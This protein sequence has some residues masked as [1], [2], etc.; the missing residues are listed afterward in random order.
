MPEF[1]PKIYK[2]D[3]IKNLMRESIVAHTVSHAYIIE[4]PD[5]SGK[6]TFAL[7]IAA[8]LSCKNSGNA[9]AVPCGECEQCEKILHGMSTDVMIIDSGDKSTIGIDS[10]RRMKEDM[11]L[12][13]TEN[14][15]KVYIID[16]AQL[17]TVQAQNAL[18]KV[19]EEPPKNTVVML[20][21]DDAKNILIT[22]KS[23][24]RL[25]RM[26]LFTSEEIE[27]YILS[28]SSAARDMKKNSS[29]RFGTLVEG[30]NGKIGRALDLLNEEKLSE[31]TEQRKLTDKI[32][33]AI[34]SS[35]GFFPIYD[36]ITA[37]P[38][39]RN[40]LIDVFSSVLCAMRDIFVIKKYASSELCYYYNRDDAIKTA[41]RISLG[42]LSSVITLTENAVTETGKNANISLLLTKFATDIHKLS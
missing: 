35:H 36:A 19:L 6:M 5:G 37:L 17:L 8:A 18:L 42:K 30:A 20:L 29:D 15:Y 25:M 40:E 4:G 10:V 41:R 21:C 26:Q 2:N 1:F 32:I 3:M 9:D 39:K 13:P 31:I 16:E 22:V 34:I 28:N 12:S 7:N 11:Y 14:D 33:E 27:K 24:A 23:R 38:Q